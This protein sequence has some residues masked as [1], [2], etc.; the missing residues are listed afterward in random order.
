MCG[1]KGSRCRKT[2]EEQRKTKVRGG[3]KASEEIGARNGPSLP[4]RRTY[5][6]ERD[7]MSTRRLRSDPPAPEVEEKVESEASGSE[8]ESDDESSDE[9]VIPLALGREKR[10]TQGN[11]MQ[12]LLAQQSLLPEEAFFREEEDDEDFEDSGEPGLRPPPLVVELTCPH[13]LFPQTR[14]ASQGR[15]LAP[16]ARRR[17]TPPV[18]KARVARSEVARRERALRLARNQDILF[19]SLSL[20]C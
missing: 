15:T 17:R 19:H 1:S 7:S 10:S 13:H 9:E 5:T 12:A 8:E 3:G 20:H 4:Q 16:R 18:V 6:R 2:V 11:R 14:T